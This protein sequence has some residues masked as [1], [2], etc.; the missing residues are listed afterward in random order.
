MYRH[1]IILLVLSAMLT[2]C[3]SLNQYTELNKR[4]KDLEA[5]QAQA[6][7]KASSCESEI[8]TLQ[9]KNDQLTATMSQIR[10]GAELQYNKAMSF[11]K[12]ESYTEAIKEFEK[13]TDRYPAD[14]LAAAAFDK[15][16]EINTLAA[17]NY[18]KITKALD[19]LKD[20]KPGS[21]CWTRKL[22]TS[23]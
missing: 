23:I 21:I 17:A 18:Q 15:L 13:L 11:Y 8:R 4:Y 6:S 20:P 2:G 12:T 16:A 19:A 14:P 7:E 5:Q 22:R 3:V 9:E 1:A 10:K